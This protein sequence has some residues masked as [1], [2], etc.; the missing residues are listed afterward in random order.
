MPTAVDLG[1]FQNINLCLAQAVG[2]QKYVPL[3]DL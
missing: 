1:S 3:T 2:T